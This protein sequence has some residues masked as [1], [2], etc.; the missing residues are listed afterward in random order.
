MP[1]SDR[2]LPQVAVSDS[3]MK[4]VSDPKNIPG[5]TNEMRSAFA[6]TLKAQPAPAG[7]APRTST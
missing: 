2:P 3:L 4:F 5:I 6:A 1:R 7:W